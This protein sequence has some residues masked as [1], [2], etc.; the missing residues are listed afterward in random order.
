MTGLSCVLCVYKFLSH[1]LHR[2]RPNPIHPPYPL[3]GHLRLELLGNAFGGSIV[4]D[5]P[6]EKSMGLFFDIGEVGME[7]TAGLQIGIDDG[8]MLPEIA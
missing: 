3:H 1:N 2:P 4:F 6:K 7:L 5:Q 8:T